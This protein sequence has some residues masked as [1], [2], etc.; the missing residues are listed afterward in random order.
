MPNP[1][2]S[3]GSPKFPT[4]ARLFRWF[5]NWRTLGRVLVGIAV[6]VTL[7][8]IF[9]GAENW[10]GH[11]AWNQYRR[12]LESRG[13]QLD[14]QALWPKA[15]PDD[16]NFFTATPF[17]RTWF[18]K[19]YGTDFEKRWKDNFSL[20]SRRVPSYRGA[21]NRR[22]FMDLV[23]WERALAAI[24]AVK[25]TPGS[26][27]QKESASNKLDLESRAKAAP[28]ILEGLKTN[29]AVFDE[30]RAASRR[31][32]ARYPFKYDTEFPTG[33][34]VP[35][36]L[37]AACTRLELRACAELALGQ[38]EKA[39]E[40]VKLIFYLADSL[41][42]EPVLFAQWDRIFLFQRAVQPVWEGLAEHAWSGP[43]LRELATHLQRHDFLDGCKLSFDAER[44]GAL[45]TIDRIPKSD[46]PFY[47]LD[48]LDGQSF[49]AHLFGDELIQFICRTMPSGWYAREKLGYCQLF[50]MYL[51]SGFEPSRKRV[52][53]A[54]IQA[55]AAEA[56]RL[57][58][59]TY[60]RGKYP[61][62]YL[63]AALGHRLAAASLLRPDEFGVIRRFC[64]TQGTADQAALACAL[65]QYRLAH[66]K[67][68]DQLEALTPQ[69][70]SHLPNDAIT[71]KPYKY[72]RTD[73]GQFVL[74]SVGWN[75]KDDGGTVALQKDGSL[76]LKNGDWV[77]EYP[78][79]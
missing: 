11:R 42:A 73:S 23:A 34:W 69:F 20:A 66:G 26:P 8:G 6:L 63:R 48:S 35:K 49:G 67:F 74:Y 56:D 70:I 58:H 13:I 1:P 15:V 65:E 29:E 7:I 57:C 14:W 22:Q 40:D 64:F 28:G 50:E 10:R 16:Q 19:P 31:P 2:P 37:S 51:R 55:N 9:Y 39:L 76:D 5:C 27:Q 46:Q 36:D 47:L 41:K 33:I 60:R 3:A 18:E 68:P 52:S 72:R 45:R 62:V 21:V 44:A 53:P 71:G 32:F 30:L 61:G 54:E 12:E 79:Q 59:Q 78:A 43:Q 25:L 77:W 38:S 4:F 75:E 17:I 24:R